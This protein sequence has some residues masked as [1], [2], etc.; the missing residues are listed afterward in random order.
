MRVPRLYQKNNLAV[1]SEIPPICVVITPL[2]LHTSIPVLVTLIEFQGHSGCRKK[3]L[4]DAL[5]TG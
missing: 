4:K 2:E 3:K 5:F 1:F